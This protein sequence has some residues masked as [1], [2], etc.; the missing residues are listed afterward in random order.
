M[1]HLKQ[2]THVACP[3][4]QAKSRMRDFMQEN[5]CTNGSSLRTT[6]GFLLA[7]QGTDAS[8]RMD[9]QVLLE[10]AISSRVTALE[11][12]W[13]VEWKANKGGPYPEFHGELVVEN[14]DYDSFWLIL[15]GTYEPPLGVAGSIFD[16]LLGRRIAS[17]TAREL[18]AR[19][20]SSIEVAFRADEMQKPKAK[21][22]P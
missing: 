13:D 9:H 17:E 8:L 22:I 11:P 20:A 5:G 19:M 18:L 3:V 14:D 21:S 2:K 1:S 15:Q 12:Q 7:G 16:T 4:S 6:L 10:L